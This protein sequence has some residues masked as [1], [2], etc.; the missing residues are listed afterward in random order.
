M[1]GGG[2]SV[3]R[4]TSYTAAVSGRPPCSTSDLRDRLGNAVD[5]IESHLGDPL[6]LEGAARRSGFSRSHFARLFQA[7]AGHSLTDYVRRRR[8]SRAAEDLVAGRSVLETAVAWGYGSQAA[9]TR[10]FSRALGVPPATYVRAVRAGDAPARVFPPYEPRMPFE[11]AEA[12]APQR[13]E[14]DGLRLA[15]LARQLSARRYASFDAVPALWDDWFTAQ[16]GRALGADPA[17]PVYGLNR[18]DAAGDL[19][20]LI[21]VEAPGKLPAG[22]RAVNVP[23]GPYALFT[24]RGQPTQTAQLLVLAAYGRWVLDPELPR[25]PGGWD[26]ETFTAEDGLPPG[27]VRCDLWV[28][29]QR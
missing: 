24:E 5:F 10:A 16:R 17:A 6:D 2:R 4:W 28:P 13:V 14:R 3:T 27:A 23:G 9:F 29:L 22:Y 7:A 8:L 11:L 20:Y 18:I 25:R 21:G 12:R 15:G 19:E 1:T 26:V